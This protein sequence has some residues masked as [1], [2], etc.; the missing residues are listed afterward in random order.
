MA[1]RK[2]DTEPTIDVWANVEDKYEV[3]SLLPDTILDLFGTATWLPNLWTTLEILV[4]G[5]HPLYKALYIS[6]RNW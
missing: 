2:R 1:I 4:T 6:K 3:T 5:S